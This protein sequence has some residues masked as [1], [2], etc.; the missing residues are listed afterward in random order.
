[1]AVAV[2]LAMVACDSIHTLT[3]KKATQGSPY[4]V[5]VVCDG[6]EWQS[7]LG[8]SLRALFATPVE[9]VNQYEPMF[10]VMR[11]TT[12]DFKGVLPAHR[13]ILKVLCS[14]DVKECSI[15][16]KYDVEAS[17]QVVL[18]FQGPSQKAMIDYLNKNGESLLQVLEIAERNRTIDLAK[19]HGVKA[20]ENIIS[21]QFGIKMH[22]PEGYLL[23]AEKKGFVWASHEYPVA[24][25]G[26]FIY[27]HPYY[28]KESISTKSLVE[29][30]NAAAKQIP[31]PSDGSYMTSVRQLPNVEDSGYVEFVPDR[32]VVRINGTDW[33]EIRGLWEVENDF[34][35][36][37][38]VSYT[39]L[40][41]QSGQLL[42]LDCYVYSPKYDKRNYLRALEHLIYCIEFP[43]AEEAKK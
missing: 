43:V 36:G 33:V 1:M 24:S 34:M 28:G 4:E 26:F 9:C 39:T 17:P 14:A 16:A 8:E 10:N 32:R 20:L 25:Q 21:K 7:P 11:I 31:G 30:R 6:P 19:Q 5:L 2:V 3:T 15:L 40:D 13:N 41:K 42:T 38:F 23:R 27:T 22:I 29:A 37:P 18:T 35:G 12:R